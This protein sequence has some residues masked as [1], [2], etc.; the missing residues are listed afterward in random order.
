MYDDAQ[1]ALAAEY[2]LGTLS[3]D[4]REHAEALLTLDPGFAASVRMWERRLGELNV[5]V[6]AVE[7][8]PELWDKIKAELPVVAPSSEAPPAASDL[9]TPNLATPN[10]ATPEPVMEMPPAPPPAESPPL[11]MTGEPGTDS[12][13]IPPP[14]GQ[15]PDAV[16]DSIAA[17]LAK[18]LAEPSE[19]RTERV[20]APPVIPPEIE[21]RV[22]RSANVVQLARRVS[23]WRRMTVV[24]GAIAAL[25]ALYIGLAQFAPGLVPFGPRSQVVAQAPAPGQL[26]ARLVA[27]LQQEPTAPAFLLTVD[28]QSRTLIVR[29]VSATPETGRSYELWLVSSQ[30]PTPRSLGIVGN[31][32]FTQRPIP[33]NF[34]VATLRTASY[35]VSLEPSGGSPSGVPTGPVLFTGKIVESVPTAAPAPRT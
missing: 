35:A 15:L 27:V 22:E 20:A 30:S 9:A 23:R 24:M 21:P 29:R 34:D 19:E 31:D 3:A 18:S 2:V 6:E 1:D 32:E 8:P 28:P 17:S 11:I 26:G 12:I 16:S 25:L 4:E 7:P 14:V 10:L 33:G 13:P 5:M